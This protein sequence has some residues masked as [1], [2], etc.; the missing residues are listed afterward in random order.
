MLSGPCRNLATRPLGGTP[1]KPVNNRPEPKKTPK[2]LTNIL[3]HYPPFC[4][5]GIGVRRAIGNK[6]SCH[7]ITLIEEFGL[8]ICADLRQASIAVCQRCATILILSFVSVFTGLSAADA[9]IVATI[10]A[11][12]VT[13]DEDPSGE[14]WGSPVFVEQIGDK[15]EYEVSRKTSYS[16]TTG[17]W[18]LIVSNP[19]SPPYV[20]LHGPYVTGAITMLSGIDATFMAWVDAPVAPRVPSPDWNWLEVWN[21]K[22]AVPHWTDVPNQRTAY[23]SDVPEPTTIIV[24]SLLGTLA[25]TAGRWRRRKAT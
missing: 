6:G 19:P 15:Y 5:S 25:I 7:P 24:W 9:S 23:W 8:Y 10:E 18:D 12:G 13:Q 17:T 14:V 11:R 1:R 22:T 16:W 20:Y 2:T 3:S 4:L 21:V